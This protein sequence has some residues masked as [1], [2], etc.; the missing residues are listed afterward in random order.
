METQGKT[1]RLAVFRHRPAA[2]D[3][4]LADCHPQSA[5]FADQ[6]RCQG[7]QR[8]K[9]IASAGGVDRSDPVGKAGQPVITAWARTSP[10]IIVAKLLQATRCLRLVMP[11]MAHCQKIKVLFRF[12][13]E[14]TSSG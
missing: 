10:A 14:L 12:I 4:D 3:I 2:I 5:V 7:W 1:D 8:F 9:A 6:P 13:S 11:R